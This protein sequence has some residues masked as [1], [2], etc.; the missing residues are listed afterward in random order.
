[1][2]SP[3]LAQNPVKTYIHH[4][5]RESTNRH[6]HRPIYTWRKICLTLQANIVKGT[7][8]TGNVASHQSWCSQWK[9][10]FSLCPVDGAI[11]LPTDCHAPY[12]RMSPYNSYLIDCTL[13]CVMF[14]NREWKNALNKTIDF[15]H[16]RSEQHRYVLVCHIHF[17]NLQINF[18]HKKG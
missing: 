3:N 2:Y 15:A 5:N 6:R 14:K 11:G 10:S 18:K 9:V 1:M 4:I 13:S 16:K 7:T 17:N 8:A 12:K